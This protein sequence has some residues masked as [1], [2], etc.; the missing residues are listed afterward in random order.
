MSSLPA[1]RSLSSGPI[2]VVG[3]GYLGAV[4]AACLAHW[5]F[6]VIALDLD[7]WKLDRLRSGSAPFFEDMLDPLLEEGLRTGRLEFTTEFTDLSLSPLVFVCVGTPQQPDSPAADLSQVRSAIH[8]LASV[9]A[10][11]A[12]VVG[13]STTPAGTAL[14]LADTLATSGLHLAWNPEF[15]REGT[16]VSDT[17]HP[18]RIVLGS[19]HPEVIEI[20]HEVYRLP[21]SDGS[22]FLSTD[23]TTAEMVKTAANAFLAA[24]VS[25]INAVSDLCD[26]TG[27]DVEMVATA[28]GLDSRIGPKFLKAGLGYGGGCFPKD[29]RALSHRASELGASPLAS[30]LDAVDAA[31][32]DARTR[33]LATLESHLPSPTATVAVLGAAF[34]PGSDD[35]RDSPA[36][37][38]VSNLLAR[39]P[40]LTITWHD[41]ALAGRT[42]T[43]ITLATSALLASADADLLVVAT[44]WPEYRSL[45]PATLHP[46]VKTLLDLRNCIPAA[47]WANSGWTVHRLG[48][49]SVHPVG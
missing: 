31:N 26:R 8:S 2:G 10:P 42:L 49:P 19:E 23:P 33:A 7:P 34:K 25:F 13:K 46:R 12:I 22:H 6:K 5:G 29:V 9:L 45:N 40:E 38:L 21:I 27:A 3:C 43:D 20:L 35:V 18:E 36:V 4:H 28:L 24:K 48:R 1:P 14:T 15:L 17:L 37:W 11:G 44:D 30:L 32:L 39:H 41:P 16:A 47:T